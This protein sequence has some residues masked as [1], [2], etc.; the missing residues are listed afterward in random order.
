MEFELIHS[1]REGNDRMGRILITLMVL[2]AGQP[3]L[4]YD[5]LVEERREDYFSAI[6]EGM[7]I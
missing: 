5:L 6:Q 2:Q 4:N 3:L 1:F 7:M